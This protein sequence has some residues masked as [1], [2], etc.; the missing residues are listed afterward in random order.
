MQSV[1]R[2]MVSKKFSADQAWAESPS[3][4]NGGRMLLNLL[5]NAA[6]ILAIWVVVVLL[7]PN[8]RD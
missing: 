6:L 7:V 4:E 8:K 5:S 3:Q 2:Q 1:A